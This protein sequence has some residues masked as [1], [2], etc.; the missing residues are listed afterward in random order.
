MHNLTVSFNL[1][2]YYNFLTIVSYFVLWA[3][4]TLQHETKLSIV[5][6]SDKLQ[7]Q[8]TLGGASTAMQAV[9]DTKISSSKIVFLLFQL[10]N[11]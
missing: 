8:I 1:V 3:K 4:F 11:A 9:S 10:Y 6:S 7:K 5:I 2:K